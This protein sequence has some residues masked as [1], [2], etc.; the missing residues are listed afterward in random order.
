MTM[1][2]DRIARACRLAG[3]DGA[4]LERLLDLDEDATAIIVEPE[5]LAIVGLVLREVGE[6]V[7]DAARDLCYAGRLDPAAKDAT[8]WTLGGVHFQER[9]PHSR[10]SVNSKVVRA[11]FP[12]EKHP[13]LYSTVQVRGSWAIGWAK[14]EK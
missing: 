2:S 4:A 9:T 6:R 13:D 14:E 1:N 3:L 7:L 11:A 12:P 8:G 5:Q 10:T